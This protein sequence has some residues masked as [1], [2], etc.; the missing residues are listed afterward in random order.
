MT[1]KE[2][3]PLDTPRVEVQKPLTLAGLRKRYNAKTVT[4]IP[5]A[6]AGTPTVLG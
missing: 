4:N 2:K 5:I 3:L 6:V 1:V